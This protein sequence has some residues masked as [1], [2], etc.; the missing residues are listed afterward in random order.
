MYNCGA[1]VENEANVIADNNVNQ[2]EDIRQT[3]NQ[4]VFNNQSQMNNVNSF[5]QTSQN[6]NNANNNQQFNQMNTSYSNNNNNKNK[7]S[8]I[9]LILGIISVVLSFVLNIF[10]IPVAI[11]GL[12]LALVDKN[13]SGKKVAGIILNSCGIIFPIII[14]IIGS[15]ILDINLDGNIYEDNYN[16]NSNTNDN[17]NYDEELYNILDS[18][19][20]WNTY[21]NLRNGN[22]G[23]V[24]YITGG[25][26]LLGNSESYWE[27]KNGNFWW[28]KSVNNLNDNYWYGTTQI[29][30][31]KKG[32][33]LAGLDESKVDSIVSSSNRK[34]TANDIYT[35]ILTPTKIISGGVDKSSTNIPQNTTWTYIWILIDHGSEGIEAQVMNVKTYETSYY[36]KL[37]D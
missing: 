22:L 27:F 12:I 18:T 13:K 15:F 33:K 30:T 34:V 3:S 17:V 2:N 8:L 21:A 25:W 7:K 16:S 36:F 29:V 24:S 32:L 26:R 9:S 4:T 1:K 10:I 11:V 31:G 19:S 6:F 14:L 28:Y 5:K 23:K 20:N 35:M 37:K